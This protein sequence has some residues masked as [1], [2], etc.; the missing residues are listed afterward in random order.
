MEY[1]SLVLLPAL[2][3]SKKQDFPPLHA[4]KKLVLSSSICMAGEISFFCCQFV[5]SC[6]GE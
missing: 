1:Y 5:R 4:S 6:D 3:I 2:V